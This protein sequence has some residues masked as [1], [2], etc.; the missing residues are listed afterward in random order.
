MASTDVDFVRSI[1][2]EWQRGEY[3]AI[4][5]AHPEIELVVA[6]GLS[7]GRWSGVAAM[8]EVMRDWLNEARELRTEP[9]EFRELD[10][11]RVLVRV[12]RRGHGRASGLDIGEIRATGANLFTV[13]DVKVTQLVV[14][15]DWDRA[16]DDLRGMPREDWDVARSFTEAYAAEDWATTMELL[17]DEH[18]LVVDPGHPN[19]GVYRG[20]E[21]AREYFR[22]WLGAFTARRWEVEE[23]APAGD[24]VVVIGRECGRGRTSG[25]PIER[26]TA[27]VHTIRGGKIVRSRLYGELSSEDAE[28]LLRGEEP[29]KMP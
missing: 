10:R 16:L 6:D 19:A 11:G 5:W 22:A 4:N 17:D 8:A 21:G 9:Q 27:V 14:Y 25:V 13:R 18:E 26:R 3:R 1:Y 12:R 15:F 23:V 29:R 24:A 2:A 28:A 7:P 20:R